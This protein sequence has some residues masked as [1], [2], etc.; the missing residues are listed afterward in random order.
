[1]SRT[2]KLRER[3][4]ALEQELENRLLAELEIEAEG[5]RSMFFTRRMPWGCD[6]RAYR[7]GPIAG[8]EDLANTVIALKE[9]L[10][11]PTSEG[12]AGIVLQY[13]RL[14]DED[15]RL[16]GQARLQFG[17]AR[18]EHLRA[19]LERKHRPNRPAAADARGSRHPSGRARR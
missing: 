14:R 15:L 16:H 10:G 8:L 7:R 11:E 12:A 19:H 1:M 3:L 6:G 4:D 5:G 18:L 13:E 9:K 17:R 2:M